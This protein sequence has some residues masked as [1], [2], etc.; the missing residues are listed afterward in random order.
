MDATKCVHEPKRKGATEASWHLPIACTVAQE[1]FFLS[2]TD[3]INMWSF[4][5]EGTLYG[6]EGFNRLPACMPEEVRV[7]VQTY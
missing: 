2:G 7:H 5:R 6:S 3:R 1:H 4:T